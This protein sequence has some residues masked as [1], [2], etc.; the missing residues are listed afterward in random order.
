[1]NQDLNAFFSTAEET[2]E[3]VESGEIKLGSRNWTE[4]EGTCL[5]KKIETDAAGGKSVIKVVLE[6]NEKDEKE[7]LLFMP[8][9]GYQP[10]ANGLRLQ[11]LQD[12]LYSVIGASKSESV[13]SVFVKIYE[14]LQKNP[15][16]C[17]YRLEERQTE[18]SKNG[19]I[20]TNQDL[21]SL[22]PMKTQ[23]TGFSL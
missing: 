22:K 18:S 4:L 6:N 10:I 9:R 3:K 23:K 17:E 2:R 16:E 13:Q 15:I 20:Y 11:N 7:F 14:I 1:M 21:V 5:F 19:K 12:V 8:N